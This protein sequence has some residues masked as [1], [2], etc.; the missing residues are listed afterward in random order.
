MGVRFEGERVG[1]GMRDEEDEA[2]NDNK[3]KER[4]KETLAF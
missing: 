4:K 3:K 1:D 2:S